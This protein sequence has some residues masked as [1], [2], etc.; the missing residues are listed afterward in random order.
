VIEAI[1]RVTFPDVA[2]RLKRTIA[3]HGAPTAVDLYHRLRRSYPAERFDE[4]LLNRLGYLLL[5]EQN[6]DSAIAIFELNASEYPDAPSPHDSLGDGYAAAGRLE[7]ALASHR[8]AVQLAEASSDARLANFSRNVERTEQRL[9][10][11]Q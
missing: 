6:T 2:R 10:E 5:R 4:E 11:R 7:E 9:R 1:R 3:A 8:R